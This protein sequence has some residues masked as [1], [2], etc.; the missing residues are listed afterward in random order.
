VASFAASCAV[1]S[2]LLADG[3]V[4]SIYYGPGTVLGLRAKAR[5]QPDGV[6]VKR[7]FHLPSFYI[8]TIIGTE[9][10]KT[11]VGFSHLKSL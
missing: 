3:F 1:D 7:M 11:H 9:K 8:W 6:S 4:M 5:V 2:F 10:R